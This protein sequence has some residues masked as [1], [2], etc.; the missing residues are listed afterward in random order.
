M[1]GSKQ[2]AKRGESGNDEILSK[3][4]KRFFSIVIDFVYHS[5]VLEVGI[6]RKD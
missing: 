5:V 1:G 4:C 6:E 2:G 3:T